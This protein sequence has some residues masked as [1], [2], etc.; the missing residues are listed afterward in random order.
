MNIIADFLGFTKLNKLKRTQ[1]TLQSQADTHLSSLRNTC[2]SDVINF[3]LSVRAK[4]R[5]D[6]YRVIDADIINTPAA[7]ERELESSID[8]YSDLIALCAPGFTELEKCKSIKR[9][10]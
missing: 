3:I 6:Q 9:L 4:S 5:I 10:T 7:V 1:L 2:E 8:I